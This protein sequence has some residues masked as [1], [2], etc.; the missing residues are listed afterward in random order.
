MRELIPLHRRFRSRHRS[1]QSP[2]VTHTAWHCF[3]D[4]ALP[5]LEDILHALPLDLTLNLEIKMTTPATC[6]V[7]PE[8]ELERATQPIIDVLLQHARLDAGRS[9][10]ISSF[11]PDVCTRIQSKLKAAEL[12]IPVMYLTEGGFSFHADSRRMSI[13][14]AVEFCVVHGLM[15]VVVNTSCLRSDPEQIGRARNQGLKVMTYGLENDDVEWI[16]EQSRL[17][18][19]GAIVDDVARVVPQCIRQFQSMSDVKESA[20]QSPM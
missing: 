20:I 3:D 12:D 13:S 7:T 18:V 11:D 1:T 5:S 8:S 19:H 14:A 15:G 16:L 6:I 17:G 2:S 10:V 9:I 4:D